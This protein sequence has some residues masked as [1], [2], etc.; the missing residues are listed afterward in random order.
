VTDK[1]SVTVTEGGTGTFQVRLSEAPAG[2][3]SVTV[4]WRSGD[5]D[6]SVFG[7]AT[8]T[9]D[10]SN[11]ST[12]QTVTLAAAQDDDLSNGSAVIRMSASGY[13]PK[14]VAANESDNDTLAFVT[15]KDSVSVPEG[16]TATFQVKL[17]NQPSG[18]VSVSVGW[19]SG[20]SDIGVSGGAA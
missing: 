2:E 19:Q 13:T 11:W 20:D 4:A 1:D 17:S 16:G 8:L 3:V 12:Y 14:D 15:D 5:T 9:F 6:I 10:A 18:E 7:G